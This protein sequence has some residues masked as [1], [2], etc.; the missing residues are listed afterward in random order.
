M[1]ER[2]DRF[3]RLLLILILVIA[4]A[5]RFFCVADLWNTPVAQVPVIDSEY[6]HAWAQELARG[7][8]RGGAG[9]F[10]MSPLYPYLLSALYRLFGSE[11]HIV[12]LLQALAGIVVVY[13]VYR[14]GVRLF[15]RNVA[16]AGAFLAALYQPFVYYENLL[17]SAV[18]ILLLNCGALLFILVPK[19]QKYH[20][21]AAGFLLGLSSLARPN[22]LIFAA[23]LC[24][25]LF[26]DA[27]KRRAPVGAGDIRNPLMLLLGI[28]LVLTPVLYR[29]A[30]VSGEWV[31]TTAGLGMN[32]YAGNNP[33]AEGIYWEA[34]FIR[35]AEPQ[36]ENEDYR[37]E[38]SRR[39][40]RS[41]SVN[42]TSRYWFAQG[43]NYIIL[44]PLDYL[45]LQLN[46]LYLFFHKT[47][48][49]NNLSIYCVRDFS[50]W[51]RRIPFTFGLI[52]PL[53]FAY[54]LRR[55]RGRDGKFR[56]V[57]LYGLS[58]FLG[59]LLFFAASEYRLPILLVLIPFAAGGLLDLVKN[60]KNRFWKPF[61]A[62]FVLTVLFAIPINMPSA[63]TNDIASPRMD[64]FN[65]G[66]V[67]LKQNRDAEAAAMLQRALFIDPHFREAHIALGDAYHALGQYDLAAEEFRRGGLD[68]ERE[69]RILNAED[70]FSEAD[71]KAMFGDYEEARRNYEEG[72]AEHPDPP[73]YAYYNL[74]FLSLQLGDTTRALD[75]AKTAVDLF[76]EEPKV[77]YLKGWIEEASGDL[78]AALRC[79][80]RVLEL[81]PVFHLARARAALVSLKKGDRAAAA[82]LIEPLLGVHLNN[83]ELNELVRSV[84][85][86]VGF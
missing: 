71:T 9:V 15:S 41:L 33:D 39:T 49:P 35:S 44:Q 50:V 78:D 14:L 66:N 24:L 69:L 73:V 10:F 19:P 51:L 82:R 76:P 57:H 74:A 67:L 48:I 29:N 26:Y 52:A 43:I 55:L 21:F 53:G 59:T 5:A 47:E 63:F 75:E 32:F 30:R 3:Q 2:R 1:R 84:A 8:E 34:P 17:L 13:L 22:V 72:I 37:L 16:L 45:K 6:Y 12:F 68:P 64:Y 79:Y 18:L 86:E 56:I 70:L 65:L 62:Q 38:A 28:M 23:L 27:L 58:Y 11:T 83:P 80:Q 40:G 81:N 77:Y 42:Q 85:T 36:Y 7:G 54:W 60:L 46:K 31:L 4:A 20:F 61:A 25:A